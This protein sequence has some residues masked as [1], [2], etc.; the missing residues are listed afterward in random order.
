MAMC[1]NV[2]R[3]LQ[4]VSMVAAMFM[5]PF[6]AWALSPDLSLRQ[7]YHTAWAATDGAPTGV[8]SLAQTADG[9]VWIAGSAGLFRF[10]GVRFERIDAFGGQRLHSTNIMRL[11]APRTGGL[12]VGYRFGGASFIIDGRVVNYGVREGLPVATLTRFAQ[13]LSGVVWVT[14]SGSLRRFN[15]STWDDVG[16]TLKLP[17]EYVK[18]MR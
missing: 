9:Y 17:S 5:L 6:A 14:T 3:L 1:A 12:W 2:C 16:A 4:Q 8:E 13:D 18:V 15:G 11:F 10:D 7:L